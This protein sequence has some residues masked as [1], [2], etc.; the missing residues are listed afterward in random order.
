MR[1]VGG[2]PKA[3]P[4]RSDELRE[5]AGLPLVFVNAAWEELTGY[6]HD[7]VLGRNC[8]LLQG[9]ET[10]ECSVAELVSS[11]RNC[12]PCL[13]QLT[14]YTREGMAFVNELSLQPVCDS[15]GKYRFVIGVSSMTC[16]FVF[17][18]S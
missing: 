15:H 7:E 12:R 10:E 4:P 1:E 18:S 6:K 3:E 9:P 2:L 16:T 14:N 8:R 5:F 17:R 13:V 11:I